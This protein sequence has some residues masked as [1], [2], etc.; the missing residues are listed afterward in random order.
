MLTLLF[1][2]YLLILAGALVR[3]TG[4]GMGCPDWPKC[5][6][7]F[8]PPTAESQLRS[9]YQ[10]FYQE[11]TGHEIAKFNVFHTYTEYINRLIAVFTGIIALV[12]MAFSFSYKNENRKMIW[13]SI[14][15]LIAIAFEGWLGK[16]VVATNLKEFVVSIHMLVSLVIV[17][18]LVYLAV[19]TEAFKSPQNIDARLLRNL[20]LVMLL[21]TGTQILLGT[22]VR[23][24]FDALAR[25]LDDKHLWIQEAG[26][27]F[28]IHRSFS[29]L[30][31][32]G[33]FFAFSKTKGM[34]PVLFSASKNL[35][36]TFL[37]QLVTGI[38]MNYFG[39]PAAAQAIHLLIGC[40]SFGIIC[41]LNIQLNP[42]VKAAIAS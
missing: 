38:V 25:R 13:F 22:Q 34:D 27:A 23:E 24:Q 10:T 35:L 12:M 5:F 9:D 3:V 37:L 32:F 11:K 28:Y 16:K 29:W 39:V 30:L 15:I 31:L 17:F 40:I 4:S 14:L 7:Q 42:K 1:T 36:I 41:Y 2:I 20:S 6:D 19:S 8:I 26:M 21:L 18:L 33:S